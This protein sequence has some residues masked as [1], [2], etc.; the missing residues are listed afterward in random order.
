M[1][2]TVLSCLSITTI[3]PLDDGVVFLP[4]LTG[5][6]LISLSFSYTCIFL[7]ALSTFISNL[8]PILAVALRSSLP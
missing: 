4:R 3:V 7:V 5:N 8:S 2:K 6:V 1:S